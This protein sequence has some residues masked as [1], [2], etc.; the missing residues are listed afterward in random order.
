M[1]IGQGNCAL[2]QEVVP[3]FRNASLDEKNVCGPQGIPS[4]AI[5]NPETG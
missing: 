2:G 4:T 5:S 1:A 3:W